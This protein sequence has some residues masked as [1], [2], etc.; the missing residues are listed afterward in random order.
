MSECAVDDLSPEVLAHTAQLAL[1]RGASDVM[2]SA[3]TMKK[4][5]SERCLPS[6]ASQAMR[7]NCSS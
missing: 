6:F 5:R 7:P 2:S 4:G 1:E 3:A